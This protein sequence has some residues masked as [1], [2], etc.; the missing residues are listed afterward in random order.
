MNQTI[1][2]TVNINLKINL[3]K[4]LFNFKQVFNF[5]LFLKMDKREI[6]ITTAM[7]LFGQKGF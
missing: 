1:P 6:I 3:I 7:K 4:R 2:V 5:A